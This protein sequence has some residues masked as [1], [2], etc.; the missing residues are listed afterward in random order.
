MVRAGGTASTSW[1]CFSLRRVSRFSSR[2]VTSEPAR[3]MGSR[4][5]PEQIELTGDFE[6]RGLGGFVCR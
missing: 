5:R 1:P 2:A 4:S 6:R 3:R